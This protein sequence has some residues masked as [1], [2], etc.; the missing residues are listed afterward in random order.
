MGPV[1]G[2]DRLLYVDIDKTLI[3]PYRNYEESDSGSGDWCVDV[4]GIDYKVLTD[5]VYLVERFSKSN[6]VSIIFWSA[7][8]A[9][10]AKQ[11]TEV[12]GIAHMGAAF[13]SKPSWTLDDV[14]DLGFAGHAD[15]WIDATKGWAK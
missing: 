13:L 5:N 10:W 11:V 3:M 4:N 12:L 9:L 15:K 6:G 2:V 7:G 1:I 14:Q 8:G